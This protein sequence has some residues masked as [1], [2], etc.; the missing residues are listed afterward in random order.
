MKTVLGGGGL[1]DAVM[2][3]L[4]L[5]KMNLDKDNVHLTHVMV[6]ET[7]RE[8]VQEFYDSQNIKAEVKLAGRDWVNKNKGRYNYHFMIVENPK[9]DEITAFPIFNLENGPKFD[10][11]ISPTAGR[12]NDRGFSWHEIN[13]FC[14]KYSYLNIGLIGQTTDVYGDIRATNLINKTSIQET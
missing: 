10:I 14:N 9:W 4:R 2:V 5:D 1:G 13:D 3:Y 8:S 6:K 11:L 12:D 7:L